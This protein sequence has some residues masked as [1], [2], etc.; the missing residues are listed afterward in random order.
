VSSD[1]LRAEDV[2]DSRTRWRPH[3]LVISETNA[4]SARLQRLSIRMDKAGELVPKLE[5]MD[6]RR[7]RSM[8]FDADSARSD[9]C[10][11]CDVALDPRKTHVWP[12]MAY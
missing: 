1:L 6:W 11:E 8:R 3:D 4:R 12:P 10:R 7:Y 2:F 9:M 5:V